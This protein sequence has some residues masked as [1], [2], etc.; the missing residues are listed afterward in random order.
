MEIEKEKLTL[1]DEKKIS[2]KKISPPFSCSRAPLLSY[3]PKESTSVTL[4]FPR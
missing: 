4:F 2:P 3:S 1:N